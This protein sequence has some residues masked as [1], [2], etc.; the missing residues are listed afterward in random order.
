VKDYVLVLLPPREMTNIAGIVVNVKQG[1]GT[2]KRPDNGE[3]VK[4]GNF[5]S[6]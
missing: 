4:V 6:K 1:D 3:V 5:I 2:L